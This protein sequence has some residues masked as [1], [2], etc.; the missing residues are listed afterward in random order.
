VSRGRVLRLVLFAAAGLSFLFALFVWLN[1]D[2]DLSSAYFSGESLDFARYIWVE[3]NLMLIA[4][5]VAVTALAVGL[6]Q[7]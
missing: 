1:I 7:R 6:R 4:L 2:A 3:I 5:A